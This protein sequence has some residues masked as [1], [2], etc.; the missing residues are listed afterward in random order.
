MP[1]CSGQPEPSHDRNGL[2]VQGFW[3]VVWAGVCVWLCVAGP[4]M[5]PSKGTALGLPGFLV[6]RPEPGT[7]PWRNPSCA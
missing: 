5:S 6:K 7:H 1:D 2:A 4:A 3:S